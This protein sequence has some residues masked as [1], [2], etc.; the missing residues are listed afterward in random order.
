MIPI[1]DDV[2]SRTFP[3]VNLT[4]IALNAV[5]FIAELGMGPRLERFLYQAAVVP[6]L[7]TGP[8]GALGLGEVFGST[9]DGP[10]RQRLL[11]SMFL[12][13]GWAHIL[14]NMLYLWI[15]GDNVEDR[16][17]HLRYAVFYLACGFAASFAHI[18]ASPL[19]E[20]PS[21][22][23]S[24][25]IAGVLGA[26]LTLYPGA[27]VVALL[28]LGFFATFVQ[29]PAFFFL[30]F[31]FL[32]QFLAGSLSL[33]APSAQAGGV[34]WWAH[35][36]GFVAGIALVFFFQKRQHRPSRRETWWDDQPRYQHRRVRGW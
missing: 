7:Y 8:D 25:A 23:A 24:G 19:S 3:I 32:Q 26:Y 2:P 15:F 16:L 18:W 5:F 36:G 27:R 29:I 14:G 4:L 10:L 22:G 9:L 12:H 11:V 35:V 17:G 30:G 21:I 33:G 1:R 28:P 34:A 6:V 20:V 31:W 13:G